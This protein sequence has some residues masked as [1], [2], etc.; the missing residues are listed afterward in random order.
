MALPT[1]SQQS[2]VVSEIIAL[3]GPVLSRLG[4]SDTS[5]IAAVLEVAVDAL[6][7]KQWKAAQAAGQA[8]ADTITTAAQAEAS[9][10]A[11]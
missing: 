4:V 3:A 8:A 9:E 7:M 1:P 5:A 2:D 11:P 10:R 6:C